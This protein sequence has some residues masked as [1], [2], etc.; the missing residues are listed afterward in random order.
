MFTELRHQIN[1]AL[2]MQVQGTAE[3]VRVRVT[4]YFAELREMLKRQEM[5]ALTV[6]DTHIRERLCMLKQQQEDMG[7]L[8]SQITTVCHQC[9]KML[10]EVGQKVMTSRLV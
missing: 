4:Q 3:K 5:S 7:V 1:A 10:Q 8:L 9:E 2:N 6:V